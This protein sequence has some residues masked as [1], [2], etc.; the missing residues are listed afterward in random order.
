MNDAV[1]PL[2][3][4]S[5]PAMAKAPEAAA[6][7]DTIEALM[8]TLSCLRP[9]AD[10][11]AR[12]LQ[13]DSGLKADAPPYCILR[14]RGTDEVAAIVRACRRE[15]RKLTIQGGRTGLAGGA[16][17]DAGD[18]VLSLELMDLIEHL[19]AVSGTAT[20][21]AGM[22]LEN[23]CAAVEA[24]GWYFPMDCGARASC[25]IGGNV[26]TNVG[27]NRVLRYGTMRE[28][29]LGL[30]VVLADGTVLTMMNQGLKNNTGLDLKHLF[31]GT[32]GTLGIVTRAVLRLFPKPERRH[33]AL[34]GLADFDQLT[35]LLKAA[36][37][38]LATLSS[39]EVMWREYLQAAATVTRRA[40]PF[41]GAYPICVL[42]EVESFADREA[43][44]HPQPGDAANGD[45]A[46]VDR[47]QA[48]LHAFLESCLDDG[49]VLDAILPQSQEHAAQ[50]WRLRDT[51]GEI[52]HTMAP[53]V[54]FDI[55]IPLALL[56]DFI[57][58]TRQALASR[59][60]TA[61][62]LLFG[63]LGDGNLHL[64]TGPYA[65]GDLEAVESLVYR[66]VER[67]G[68]SISAEHGIGRI[69]KPFLHHS[70]SAPERELMANIR[71]L[72]DPQARLNPGRIVD[73]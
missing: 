43:S 68:G 67:V 73:V 44:A 26:A 16:V 24:Q 22:V 60:P 20:V 11:V 19:D 31:I 62:R 6:M 30:E 47:A 7:P 34:V 13:D 5:R 12:Y 41:D 32:E 39:F 27:G 57:A 17:P 37:G 18:V 28:L 25:Q 56:P 4:S 33:S 48:D 59:W 35:A 49:T 21:Q 58:R 46:A 45:E 53:Y 64:S 10:D 40:E 42:L 1:T 29:V 66:E 50:L 36:R 61:Q 9:G 55:G 3:P 2:E 71:R 70:R 69:K 63:H 54:A 14:P 38:R 51:I 15:G 65:P 52:L 8:R 72:L 23:L